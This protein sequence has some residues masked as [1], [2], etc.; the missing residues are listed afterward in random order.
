M[1]R[2]PHYDFLSLC[3]TQIDLHAA[4]LRFLSDSHE[5]FR[6]AKQEQMFSRDQCT[7]EDRKFSLL[8]LSELWDEVWL[9]V[10]YGVTLIC[11][12]LYVR[13]IYLLHL[14]LKSC[15]H[16]QELPSQPVHLKQLNL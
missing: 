2:S 7:N 13:V 4:L 1:N 8:F 12:W 6:R 10:F 15:D 11:A 9:S 5:V 3:E 16:Q 14:E